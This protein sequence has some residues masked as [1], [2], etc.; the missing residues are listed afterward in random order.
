VKRISSS[1][2]VLAT[3]LATLLASGCGGTEPADEVAAAT[4]D[5]AEWVTSD[6]TSLS[7]IVDDTPAL[8]DTDLIAPGVA[9]TV[10]DSAAPSISVQPGAEPPADLVSLIVREGSGN[11]VEV[12]DTVTVQYCGVGL[13]TGQPFDSSWARGAPATF[14]LVEGGLIQGWIDGVPGMRVGE[15]RV[16]VIPGPL[17]YGDA[18]PGGSIQPN[19][20]LV[21]L[22]ELVDVGKA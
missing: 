12:N 19:E 10:T 3:L 6:C 2:S 22:I 17:A 9:V 7:E 14:E 5:S 20:T 16:L 18:S 15:Q 1:V 13:A 4:P 21:F 11:A 8:A